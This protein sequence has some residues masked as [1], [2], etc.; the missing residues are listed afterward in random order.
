MKI[1][2]MFKIFT[3]YFL[4][5]DGKDIE[6]ANTKRERLYSTNF[7]TK[8]PLFQP[9]KLKTEGGDSGKI[10]IFQGVV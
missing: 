3:T 6:Y 4:G 1:F 5:G 10:T 8:L 2:Y 9:L 7:S